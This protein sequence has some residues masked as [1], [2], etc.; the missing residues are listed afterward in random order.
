MV[1]LSHLLLLTD[2]KQEADNTCL[3]EGVMPIWTTIM[4]RVMFSSCIRWQYILMVLIP[5]LGSSVE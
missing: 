3:A 1:C 4:A 5:T 2:M